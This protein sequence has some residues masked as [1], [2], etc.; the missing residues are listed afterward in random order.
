MMPVAVFHFET[1]LNY[2]NQNS[3]DC[4]FQRYTGTLDQAGGKS[5][6]EGIEATKINLFVEGYL[7]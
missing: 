6:G 2:F 7:S 3:Q 4:Y 5:A 1:S